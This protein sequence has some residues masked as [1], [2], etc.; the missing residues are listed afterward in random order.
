MR[1]ARGARKVI[2]RH[3]IGSDPEQFAVT[4]DGTRLYASN[5]DGGTATAIDLRTGKQIATL[6]VSIEPE[7]VAIS[8]DGR[9][10]VVTSETSNTLS[11]IDIKA[12]KIVDNLIVDLR[13]RAAIF[14]PN[15]KR[16]Y[17]SAEIWRHDLCDRHHK[18]CVALDDRHRSRRGKTRWHRALSRRSPASTLSAVE[19]ER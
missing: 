10:A 5:E 4:P 1:G 2:A 18:S 14:S 6:V 17:V 15:G 11:I 3:H 9:L 7:G 8:P 19:P 16:L 13:P 12:N